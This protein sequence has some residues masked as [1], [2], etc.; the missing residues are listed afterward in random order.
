MICAT[1]DPASVNAAQE[2]TGASAVGEIVEA[3]LAACSV[4]AR[5]K[6]TR[7]FVVAGGETSGAVVKALDVGK[8]DVGAEIVPGVSLVFRSKWRTRH[9]DHAKVRQLWR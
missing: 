2:K 1:A 6:G 8:P 4:A 9:C 7:R 5:D 3:E